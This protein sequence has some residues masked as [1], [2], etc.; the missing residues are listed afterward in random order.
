MKMRDKYVS[1]SSAMH[2]YFILEPGGNYVKLE[3]QI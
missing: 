3:P 1:I 2:T